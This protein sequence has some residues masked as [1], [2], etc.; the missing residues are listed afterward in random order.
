MCNREAISR[1]TKYEIIFPR[2]V[3]AC[4]FGVGSNGHSI[5]GDTCIDARQPIGLVTQALGGT[6]CGPRVHQP[7]GHQQPFIGRS[8]PAVPSSADPAAVQ[9]QQVARQRIGSK[10]DG[11][12]RPQSVRFDK[13]RTWRSVN[14]PSLSI[15]DPVKIADPPTHEA[16]K[17]GA[18]VAGSMREL[19]AT[20][21][22]VKGIYVSVMSR[23]NTRVRIIEIGC[24]GSDDKDSR[25]L[26]TTNM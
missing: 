1:L 15:V 18:T 3:V 14:W 23:S 20:Y 19:S 9:Q 22:R 7:A 12:R 24:S 11:S 8:G 5:V 10:S 25:Q 26:H 6:S 21:R 17:D 4:R 16:E 2:I 13:C